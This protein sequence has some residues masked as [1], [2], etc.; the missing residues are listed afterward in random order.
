MLGDTAVAVHPEDERYQRPDRQDGAS[1]RWSTGEIPVIA[2]DYV[3]REFGTGVVKITPA[4]DFNDF[5][6]GQRHNLDTINVID[7]SAIDQRRP[8]A[9]TRAWTAS[10]A[11]RRIV[12]DWRPQGFWRRSTTTTR[13]VGRCYR[14]KT[15]VE[16]L[17]L[18]AVVRE[19]RAP[20]RAR[21]WPRCKDGQT[22]ILPKQWENT[23][24]DWM[25][26]IRD[27]CISRQIWWGHR[28]PAWFCDHCGD[29]TVAHGRPRRTAPHAAATSSAR[30]PT[31]WTPG[32]PRPSGPSPPWAGRT[33]RR[34]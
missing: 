12:A 24:Y 8:A 15:V 16:P 5:E 27:W 2:D 13:S 7:E 6:V 32:S 34:S 28:I 4:H 10:S 19:G 11:A 22:R 18:H 23:Y 1:C 9:S 3:D 17:P 26:N 21:P 29:V 31:S 30:R 20:G 25:E 33:D 14:C